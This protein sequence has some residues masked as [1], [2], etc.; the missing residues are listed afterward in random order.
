PS[1]Q[2][3]VSLGS[4]KSPLR[5]PQQPMEAH[6]SQIYFLSEPRPGLFEKRQFLRRG[7]PPQDGVAMG[8]T[9]EAGDDIAVEYLEIQVAPNA[10]GA[11]QFDGDVVNAQG[12]TVHI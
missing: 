9:A 1:E 2:P 11:E 6:C 7:L 12:F 8:I 5:R 3:C 4:C 10:V